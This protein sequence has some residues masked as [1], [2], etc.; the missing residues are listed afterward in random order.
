MKL[1][2]VTHYFESHRGGIEIVAGQL[3]REFARSGMEVTWLATDATAA[4]DTT[5]EPRLRAVS[6]R[7]NVSLLRAKSPKSPFYSMSYLLAL[8]VLKTTVLMN[9]SGERMTP[10]S[11]VDNLRTATRT[12]GGDDSGRATAD[13]GTAI[14]EP[15]YFTDWPTLQMTA[16]WG[17]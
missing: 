10:N 7:Q 8:G 3:A 15:Q 12:D 5:T 6:R 11:E 9:F 14:I 17:N 4:P 2:T 16:T 1:L 13:R